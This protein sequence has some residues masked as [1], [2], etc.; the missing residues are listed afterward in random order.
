[1]ARGMKQLDSQEVLKTFGLA[2]FRELAT[3]GAL[4]D[5]AIEWMLQQGLIERVDAG[6]RITRF[7]DAANSFHIVLDGQTAFYIGYDDLRD[8]DV[9]NGL[10]AF[11]CADARLSNINKKLKKQ[12]PQPL[13]Q[14]VRN[15]DEMQQALRGMDRF[16]LGRTPNFEPMRGPAIPTYFAAP[17]RG[18]LYMPLRSGPDRAVCTWLGAIDGG[19]AADVRMNFTQ[20]SL[21][22]WQE[23]HPRH[24]SFAVLRHPVA[25]AHA[26]FCDRILSQ[27]K[28]CFPELRA[29]L[30]KVHKLGIPADGTD[31]S[32]ND[33]YDDDAHQGAFLG[34]LK[35][36]KN[37]LSGQTS[38]R[39]DPSW[40]SQHTL[41][42]GMA[43]YALPD[44]ILREDD[45]NQELP[46]LAS[47][48]GIMTAPAWSRGPH[49]QHDR[50]ATVYNAQIEAA[51]TEAYA[52]DY[53]VFGFESWGSSSL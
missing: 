14:K 41:L 10:A 3:F 51:A 44:V 23:T 33:G 43:Q 35:F 1:M 25:R 36:L 9:V 52:F 45:L 12:N 30:R 38:I 46:H 21:R 39:V 22:D 48:I 2:Y 13:D 20:R 42:Q 16:D 37:N 40:A 26:A 49:L 50:L 31:F 29:N 19:Q 24:R 28:G 15:F 27:D 11:L 34:F 8:V 5:K 32:G 7:G 53:R 6:R 4:S 47:Q 18:L 17:K